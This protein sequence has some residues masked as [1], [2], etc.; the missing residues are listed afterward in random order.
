MRPWD[1]LITIMPTL[2][3]NIG[4]VCSNVAALLGLAQSQADACAMSGLVGSIGL[5]DAA[6]HDDGD[7]NLGHIP[8][9]SEVPPLN[10]VGHVKGHSHEVSDEDIVEIGDVLEARPARS[11]RGDIDSNMYGAVGRSRSDTPVD[12]LYDSIGGPR[13]YGDAVGGSGSPTAPGITGLPTNV[14]APLSMTSPP[15]EEDDFIDDGKWCH[16]L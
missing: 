7:V 14:M 1:L 6:L 13:G 15:A 4:D 11:D 9:R 16:F 10:G 8:S 3:S 2:R 5:R 12:G